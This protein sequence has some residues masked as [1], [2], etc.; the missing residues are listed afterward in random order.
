M[1]NNSKQKEIRHSQKGRL[2]WKTPAAQRSFSSGHLSNRKFYLAFPRLSSKQNRRFFEIS[3]N[4]PVAKQRYQ[5]T[6]LFFFLRR[7]RERP[8]SPAGEEAG[9]R[10]VRVC[11][12]PST[13]NAIASS[14]A[15]MLRWLGGLALLERDLELPSA[16]EANVPSSSK[17]SFT[18]SFKSS[19]TSVTRVSGVFCEDD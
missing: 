13:I 19:A 8:R 17:S 9:R 14:H 16:G 18:S 7:P 2:H 5:K 6:Q 3:Q 11:R 10:S 12:L 15:G 4:W 1:Y